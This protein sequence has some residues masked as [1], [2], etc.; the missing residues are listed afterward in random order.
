MKLT[1]ATSRN[2]YVAG[3]VGDP[4]RLLEIAARMGRVRGY[5][6]EVATGHFI[7]LRQTCNIFEEDESSS[8]DKGLADFMAPSDFAHAIAQLNKTAETGQPTEDEFDAITAKGNPIRISCLTRSG[9]RGRAH[10]KGTR[11][12]QR[13]HA[14]N[15]NKPRSPSCE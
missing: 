14:R 1:V 12:D 5:E 7:W 2:V 4:S 8:I 3:D 6:Y 15:K 13:H 11:R 9:I 10:C